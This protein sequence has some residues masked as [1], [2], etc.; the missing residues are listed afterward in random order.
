MAVH[1]AVGATIWMGEHVFG[2]EE[3]TQLVKQGNDY[4][5]TCSQSASGF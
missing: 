4:G 3:R 5:Y 1:A 2:S